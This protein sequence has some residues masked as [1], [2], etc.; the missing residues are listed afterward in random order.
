MYISSRLS[1]RLHGP[2]KPNA[3]LR[4]RDIRYTIHPADYRAGGL[5]YAKR[6]KLGWRC[7]RGA[8]LAHSNA[9]QDQNNFQG[10]LFALRN[11]Y[12]TQTPSILHS[13]TTVI[14]QQK[15]VRVGGW[16]R[17]VRATSKVQRTDVDEPNK[18]P[19]GIY[20]ILCMQPKLLV[21]YHNLMTPYPQHVRP[22]NPISLANFQEA[23]TAS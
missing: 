21:T 19:Q 14:V 1:C 15:T 4:I 9:H 12:E 8:T 13:N 2:L 5:G 17:T 22:S 6:S 18:S 10:L 7:L 20:T 3:R 23:N 11:I 16:E